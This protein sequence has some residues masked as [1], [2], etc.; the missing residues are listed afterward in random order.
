MKHNPV[1]NKFWTKIGVIGV[2][3]ALVFGAGIFA[4]GVPWLR[5]ADA[6]LH[7]DYAWQVY[8]GDLPDFYEGTRAP[9]GGKSSEV[10]FVSQ[11]PP[12]YYAI[13]APFVGPLLDSGRWQLATAVGRAITIF[14]SAICAIALA[15]AGWE[16]GGKNKHLFAIALPAIATS[17]TVFIKVAALTYND[18]LPILATVICFTL[19]Y[20]IITT[21]PSTKMT[22]FLAI[23]SLLGMA[24][25]AS[26]ISAFL[27]VLLGIPVSFF[28]HSTKT[29]YLKTIDGILH[30]MF[31]L[32][33]VLCG[34]GW[35]YYINYSLTGNFTRSAPQ[36]WAADLMGRQYK[37][38]STVL[39]SKEL[40]LTPII[41]LYGK[42]WPKMLGMR[43]NSILS[44]LTF[45]IGTVSTLITKTKQK[46]WKKLNPRNIA[47]ISLMV[48]QIL[49]IFGQQIVHATGYGGYMSRYFLP[50]ILPVGLVLTYGISSLSK[51]KI[52]AIMP[53]VLLG[54][55]TVVGNT[56]RFIIGRYNIGSQDQLWKSLVMAVTE[57]NGIP[58]IIIPILF[59]GLAIGIGIQTL[60]LWKLTFFNNKKGSK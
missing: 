6:P 17:T 45:A 42:E 18:I 38:L 16:I 30:S 60:A 29:I 4:S 11:H 47:F 32:V 24:S 51:N 56:L 33:T 37:S 57:V 31:V 49:L 48:L 43:V 35:F 1:D 50:T 34:I 59:G 21:G 27:L 7:M 10:Q 23:A 5:T 39:F 41:E 8:H 12:L 22:I 14:L 9:L 53:F 36:S 44:A 54:W 2:L 58:Y 52:L 25:R 13:L 55:V 26:F 3:I 20:K 15:W 46:F 19:L 28:I 40:W